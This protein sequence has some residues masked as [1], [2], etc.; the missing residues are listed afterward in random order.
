MKRGYGELSGFT[1]IVDVVTQIIKMIAEL[2][3]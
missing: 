3:Y 1:E 2:C